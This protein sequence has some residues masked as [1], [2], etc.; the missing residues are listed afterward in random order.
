MIPAVGRN[1][2]VLIAGGAVA[3]MLLVLNWRD[4]RPNNRWAVIVALL[5]IGPYY[6]AYERE[7][8][9]WLILVIAC[10]VT[11]VLLRRTSSR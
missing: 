5:G 6:L 2:L 3:L 9:A 1:P 7:Q 10:G 11:A 8:P 4:E